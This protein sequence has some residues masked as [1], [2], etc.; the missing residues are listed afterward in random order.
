MDVSRR[1]FSLIERYFQ[2]PGQRSDVA[3]GIGDDGAIVRPPADS[4][5]VVCTDTMVAGVHFDDAT[6]AKAIGHKLLAV[7]LSD[8]AAMGAEPAWVSLA[9]TLPEVDDEWLAA[10][11]EGFFAL[12]DHY[13]CTLIGGDVTRGPALTLTVTVHGLV[14]HGQRMLRSGASPGDYIYVTG[15]LGD[16]ALALQ[17]QLGNLPCTDAQLNRLRLKLHL[18]EPRVLTGQAVRNHATSA[19]DLSDGLLG[20]L[21][22]LVAASGCG[23][24]LD[25]ELLPRSAVSYEVE[26]ATGPWPWLVNGGDDYELLFTLPENRGSVLGT[27]ASLSGVPITCIGQME[28]TPGVRLW[29]DGESVTITDESYTHFRE[30]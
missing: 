18:P 26:P 29:H 14:P 17:A 5:V 7:N 3:L 1:E 25:T 16:A 6:P 30:S 15:D 4:S 20:D 8:L 13:R 21:G 12:A 28:R 9:L 23:A 22:H 2:R 10:F 11:S 24:R 19:I 27:I